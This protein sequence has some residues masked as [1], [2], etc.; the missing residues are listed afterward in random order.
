MIKKV[1]NLSPRYVGR[2]EKNYD[3]L[4]AL[5]GVSFGLN[6]CI[7]LHYCQLEGLRLISNGPKILRA[8]GLC[9]ACPI[10]SIDPNWLVGLGAV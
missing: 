6:V 9:Q 3:S 1:H 7:R 5:A 4:N 8:H 2:F 10:S